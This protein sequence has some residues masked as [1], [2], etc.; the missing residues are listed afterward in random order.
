[1]PYVALDACEEVVVRLLRFIALLMLVA[2]GLAFVARLLKPRPL[3]RDVEGDLAYVGP[4]P[5]EGP[6]V[7]VPDAVPLSL[8]EPRSPSD[9]TTPVG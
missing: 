8:P 9:Q 4:T 2:A 7:S 5:A 1:M 6:T 3:L